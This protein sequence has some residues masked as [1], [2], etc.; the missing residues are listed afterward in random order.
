VSVSV[1][2]LDGLQRE[3]ADAAAALQELDGDIATVNFDPTDPTSVEA[4]VVQ[5]EQT[6]DAKVASYRGNR[7]V[8]NFVAQMKDRYRQE[9]YDKA[10]A[11][12]LKGETL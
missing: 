10:A 4:A 3:L 7:I 11:A 12:R 6:I 2:G 1:T 8:D 9:I 5:I